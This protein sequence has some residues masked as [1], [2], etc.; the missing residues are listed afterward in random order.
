MINPSYI[1]FV[2]SAHWP[3]ALTLSQ[4][5][6]LAVLLSKSKWGDWRALKL[7]FYGGVKEKGSASWLGTPIIEA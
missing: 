6:A 3:S 7:N 2:L 1:E 4:L 5:A